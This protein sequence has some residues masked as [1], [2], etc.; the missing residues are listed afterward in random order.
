MA[1]Q[2]GQAIDQAVA[3]ATAP[4]VIAA[5]GDRDRVLQERAAGRLS[6][7][8]GQPARPGTMV[9]PA[10]TTKPITSGAALRRPFAT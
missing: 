7:G 3:E 5:A 6:Q 8:G 2:A 4:G 1:R 10:S 9:W